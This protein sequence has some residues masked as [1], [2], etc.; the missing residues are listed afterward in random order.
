MF[1]DI[2]DWLEELQR[3]NFMFNDYKWGKTFPILNLILTIL[4]EIIENAFS[5]IVLPFLIIM[6]LIK[7]VCNFKRQI[8]EFKSFIKSLMPVNIG[9][10]IN[11]Y[12]KKLLKDANYYHLDKFVLNRELDLKTFIKNFIREYNSY[13]N[14]YHDLRFICDKN[15]RRSLGDIFLICRC[16]FPTCTLKEVL[17]YLIELLENGE[18]YGSYCSTINKYVF[19]Y[20]TNIYYNNQ[21]VEYDENL[22]FIHFVNYYEK[23]KK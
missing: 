10:I 21:P 15:K 8:I 3:N 17:G 9:K 1:K 13:Y 11:N 6:Y 12:E 20:Q 2:S 16:Y 22:Q 14:T 5:I 7:G 19:H 23:L 18:I 4:S